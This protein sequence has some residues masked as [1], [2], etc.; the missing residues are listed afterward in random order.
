MSDSTIDL[1]N[2]LDFIVKNKDVETRV[3]LDADCKVKA[4]DP[5][6]LIKIINYLIN[7]LKQITDNAINISLT[8]Q[9]EGC[10]LCLIVSTNQKKLPPLSENL[11]KALKSFNAA[12]RIV[13]EEEKYVQLLI[14]FCEGR[15]PDAVVIE[16]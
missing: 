15:I 10:L 13:F 12:I 5:K 9:S 7:Y 2:L 4:E 14:C 16:V 3:N 1:R 8:K 6:P 11:K